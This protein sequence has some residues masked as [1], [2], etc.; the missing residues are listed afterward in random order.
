MPLMSPRDVVGWKPLTATLQ[1]GFAV[2]VPTFLT[3]HPTESHPAV[4][5]LTFTI[6]VV[7][8][9]VAAAGVAVELESASG[10]VTAA[11]TTTTADAIRISLLCAVR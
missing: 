4:G 9:R 5:E 2:S 6:S 7:N 11:A 10:I 3:F 8:F 1:S